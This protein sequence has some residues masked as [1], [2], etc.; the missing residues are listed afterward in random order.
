VPRRAREPCSG[1][2][3]SATAAPRRRVELLPVSIMSISASTTV[4]TAAAAAAAHGPPSSA[5]VIRAKVT[6]VKYGMREGKRVRIR[7]GYMPG[8]PASGE[9]DK[10]GGQAKGDGAEPPPSASLLPSLP[11]LSPPR[12]PLLQKT[13][14]PPAL[15]RGVASLGDAVWRQ[16]PGHDMDHRGS[17]HRPGPRGWRHLPQHQ[18]T[19]TRSPTP[20]PPPPPLLLP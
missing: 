11:R 4:A 13:P 8:A 17:V 6:D 9:A 7:T 12:P 14:R 20:L 18:G 16:V 3:R 2:V 15:P 10:V 1:A 19:A 5:Q